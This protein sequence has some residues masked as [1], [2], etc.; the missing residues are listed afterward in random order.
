MSLAGGVR[1]GAYEIVSLIGS[2]G[3]GEVYRARDPRLARDVAIKVLPSAFSSDIE[4]LR[5]FE[6]EA[7]AA[8]ALSHPNILAVYELGTHEN[9]PYIVSELL[10]GETLRER[11]QR[12]RAGALPTRKAIDYAIQIARGLSAAHERGIVHRDLKP[13]NIFVTSD[14]RAKILD[15]GLAKLTERDPIG[16]GVSALPTTPPDTLPGVVLGTIGYMSPE[17]VRGLAADHRSDLFSFGA[18]LY[19][20]CSGQRAF[21]GDT[22]ADTMSAVLKEDPPD[23]PAADRQLPPALLRILDRCL[24][25]S[26]AAR[27]QSAGDLAFALEALSGHSGATQAIAGAVVG[28]GSRFRLAWTLVAVLAVALATALTWAAIAQFGRAPIETSMMRFTIAPPDGWSIPSTVSRS[29]STT[30]IGGLLPMAVSPDGRRV[31]F[32]ARGGNQQDMLWVRAFDTLAA[33]MVPGTE[34]VSAPFW[35]PDSR[36]IAFFAGGK[37]KKIDVGGGPPINLCDVGNGTGGTWNRDGVILFSDGTAR[38]SSG[39]APIRRVSASGGVATDATVPEKGDAAH[40]KPV[41]LPDGRH[42]LFTTIAP[43]AMP[44]YV[45]SLDSPGRTKILDVDASN[46]VYSSGHLLFLRGTTLMAQPFDPRRLAVSGDMVPVS[47]PIR[48]FGFSGVPSG[49]FSVSESGVLVYQTGP[50][51]A[52][53]T[54]LT[55]FDRSGRQ[56]STLG[57]RGEYADV[58][59]SPDGKQAAVTVLESAS[60]V[61]LAPAD[62]WIFDL[63]RGIRTRLTSNPASDLQAIWSPD[64]ARVVF[65]SSR[66][67]ALDL[68]Q[69]SSNGG[70]AEEVLLAD[71][72]WKSAQSWSADGRYI[73][74][75]SVLP[76][77]AGRGS[78]REGRRGSG[79]EGRRGMTPARENDSAR[80]LW[81]LPLFGDRK[82]APMLL[83]AFVNQAARLSPDGRWVVYMSIESGRPE[84]FVTSFPVPGGKTLVST[85]GGGQP[86]WRRDG[87]EIFYRSAAQGGRLM[88]APVS[89]KGSTLEVGSTQPLFDT[90]QLSPM[91]YA[92]DVAADGQ[93]F[94]LNVQGQAT[95]ADAA[96]PL[97]VVVNWTAA[98]RR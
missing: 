81:A 23:L 57:A 56:L 66:N 36:F 19:E 63:A 72:R 37:L 70:G 91:R 84:V 47:E 46:V 3:M 11:L 13:E 83:S 89:A 44:V 68:L 73:L 60:N 1:L 49:V 22:S 65:S 29:P 77:G 14:G 51:Q 38:S 78:G 71:D 80:G 95:P 26:P 54:Q 53:G 33:Q 17:Q 16:A 42:F 7:R 75:A 41:F 4:R 52:T 24:E 34:G 67:G 96:A 25:K 59:L 5:R 62:V 20:L 2:G 94:L 61:P 15:F 85:D 69:R 98:I 82:P 79:S 40:A 31:V 10:E 28:R 30:Q 9:A 76:P 50:P 86:R 97:T 8:A 48:A 12:G 39:L 32:I 90:P 21:R 6:Q 93:R 58:E 35:S 64:S 88:A 92:Y 27:F 74:F 43:V 55:W 87:K 45:A 18:I